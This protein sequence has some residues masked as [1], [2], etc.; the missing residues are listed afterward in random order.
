MKMQEEHYQLPYGEYPSTIQNTN[1][2]TQL[3]PR[4]AEH[5]KSK[6]TVSHLSPDCACCNRG[7]IGGDSDLPCSE[8]VSSC[9][10]WQEHAMTTPE[11]CLT[12][13]GVDTTQK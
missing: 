2:A 7:L 12:C 10:T 1:A 9:R 4:A 6:S 11:Q 8:P 3:H 13:C 5:I